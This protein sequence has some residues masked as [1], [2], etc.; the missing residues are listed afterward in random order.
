MKKIL[1]AIALLSLGTM[2]MAQDVKIKNGKV[3]MSEAD[4][5]RL[6][7][8][9][10]GYEI[11]SQKLVTAQQEL[12]QMEDD[13]E[14]TSFNDSASYAIGMDVFNNWQQQKLGINYKTFAM[15]INDCSKGLQKLSQGDMRILLGRFQ[16]DF[17]R[18]Q[19]EAVQNNIDAGRNYLKT[20]ANNKSVYTTA[21]GL[22]YKKIK[23]GN[24]KRPTLNDKVKVHYTGR[25]IDGTIFDSSVQRGNPIE[26]NLNQVIKGWTEGLQLMDE[27]SKYMLFIPYEL[28][29]GE[30]DMG[31]IP[32]GSTLIF[33]VELLEILK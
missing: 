16:Q 21:S 9:A 4:Y 31:D 8:Q 14:L 23:E 25:L 19:R 17:E 27:G 13:V 33:E 10:H 20:N 18:R 29:Y 28:G 26:F 24:G 6:L 12:S 5:N 3:T 1:I 7:E 22:Q 11:V 30:R 32:A 15:S 2:T